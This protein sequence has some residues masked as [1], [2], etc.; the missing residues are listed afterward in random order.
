MKNLSFRFISL[1]A[2]AISVMCGTSAANA[3]VLTAVPMQG[4]MV[5]PMVS[6]NAAVGKIQVM[7]PSEIPQ[8]TPLLVSNPADSFDPADPWYDEL[9][10]SCQG[11][12]FSRRYGFVM[13]AMSDPLPANTQMWIRKLSGPPE[14]KFYW[15]AGSVPKAFDPIFGTE[16][17]TNA[18]FWNGAMFHPAVAAPPGTNGYISTFEVY[19]LDTTSGQ[20][21]P[22]SSSGPLV[23]NW[24]NVPDGRPALSIAQKVVVAWPA[25]TTT[26]WVLE[27]ASSPIATTWTL[28]TNPPVIVD[29]EPCVVLDNDPAQQYFRMRY[30]P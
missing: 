13:A 29:G 17:V 19:L 8:L 21:V 12:S 3:A 15:Y 11:A 28:V 23:L 14:L 30:L 18:L 10:P 6:Y 9:D 16:G 20:A 25:A 27:S 1:A 4:G 26:N 22:N 2:A 24:T 5:M 7:M